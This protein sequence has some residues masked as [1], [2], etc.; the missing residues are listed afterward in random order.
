MFVHSRMMVTNAYTTPR[1]PPF[2]RCPAQPR[3][4]LADR[5]LRTDRPQQPLTSGACVY[6]RAERAKLRAKAVYNTRYR[7]AD[8]RK[9]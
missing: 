4:L 3:L 7:R 1:F 8:R 9:I 2:S 5:L 6:T